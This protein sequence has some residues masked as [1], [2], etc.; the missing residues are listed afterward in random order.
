MMYPG[1]C[2]MILNQST[3]E[4]E[5]FAQNYEKIKN[6]DLKAE[7][8]VEIAKLMSKSQVDNIV[9]QIWL[10][11]F[12]IN[13]KAYYAKIQFACFQRFDQF[14]DTKFKT[15]KRYGGEGGESAMV[16]YNELFKLAAEGN[17][18]SSSMI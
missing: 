7:E 12:V 8:Q 13:F 4:R 2:T 14:V 3:A 6:Q 9:I 11:L 17:I 18:L 5:W 16:F 1:T 10:W 15:I